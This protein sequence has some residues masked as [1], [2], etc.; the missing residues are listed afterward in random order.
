MEKHEIT[1]PDVILIVPMELRQV[2]SIVMARVIPNI[3][4]IAREEIAAEYTTE[5]IDRV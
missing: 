2:T 5:I 1:T 4:V 3:R